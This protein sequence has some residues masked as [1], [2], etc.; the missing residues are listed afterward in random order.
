MWWLGTRS[1]ANPPHRC[2][3]SAPILLTL[4]VVLPPLRHPEA[5]EPHV[6]E[7]EGALRREGVA[8]PG[9]TCASPRWKVATRLLASFVSALICESRRSRTRR[10]DWEVWSQGRFDAGCLRGRLPTGISQ[11]PK[12]SINKA[13]TPAP[14][15]KAARPVSEPVS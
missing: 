10:C 14:G 5:A 2:H 6:P 4:R 8:P 3:P 7:D 13:E 1:H 9:E 12:S 11:R 15:R